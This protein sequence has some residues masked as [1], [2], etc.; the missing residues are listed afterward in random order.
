MS[1]KFNHF[2]L[3][4]Y[5]QLSAPVSDDTFFIIGSGYVYFDMDFLQCFSSAGIYLFFYFFNF[6]TGI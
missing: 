2:D 6:F 5:F 4:Q 1:M 3:K